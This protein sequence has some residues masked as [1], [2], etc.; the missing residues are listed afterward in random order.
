M[1][2]NATAGACEVFNEVGQVT[3]Q[4]VQRIVV[5]VVIVVL[6]EDND[7]FC[8]ALFGFLECPLEV[9]LYQRPPLL[10]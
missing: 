1:A 8:S 10:A 9:V 2:A 4:A 6:T 7:T 3:I 5:S